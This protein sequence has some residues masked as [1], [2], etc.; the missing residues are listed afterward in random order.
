[1][2]GYRHHHY[3]LFTRNPVSPATRAKCEADGTM[4][5]DARRMYETLD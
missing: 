5:V 1:M 2:R 4:L 3:A